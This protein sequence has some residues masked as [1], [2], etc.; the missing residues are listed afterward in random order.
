M[1]AAFFDENLESRAQKWTNKINPEMAPSLKIKVSRQMVLL[2]TTDQPCVL[3]KG[4][5][6]GRQS[7]LLHSSRETKFRLHLKCGSQTDAY[8][9]SKALHVEKEKKHTTKRSEAGAAIVS[10]HFPRLSIICCESPQLSWTTRNRAMAMIQE[11]VDRNRTSTI[12]S[13]AGPV[14]NDAKEEEN[15]RFS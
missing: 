13:V 8:W 12:C 14:G 4:S 6:G 11:A 9:S 10:F 1:C 15:K 7:Q 2:L 3:N 5:K